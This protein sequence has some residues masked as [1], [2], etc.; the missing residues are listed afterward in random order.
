MIEKLD[1]LESILAE[2]DLPS[3]VKSQLARRLLGVRRALMRAR[4]F[5]GSELLDA[6]GALAGATAAAQAAAQTVSPQAEGAL[7]R[8]REKVKDVL[9]WAGRV[10]LV[11]DATSATWIALGGAEAIKR[12]AGG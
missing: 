1:E 4:R 3:G 9:D 10:T 12:I 7:D 2:T 11:W 5:G 6:A 8:F